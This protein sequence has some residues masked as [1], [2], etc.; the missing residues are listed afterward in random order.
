MIPTCPN[1]EGLE[2]V[3]EPGES[4]RFCF[5]MLYS[6][7]ANRALGRNWLES[8]LRKT[9]KYSCRDYSGNHR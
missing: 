4:R 6:T 5:L 1:C 2:S 3:I 7:G 9:H 8:F